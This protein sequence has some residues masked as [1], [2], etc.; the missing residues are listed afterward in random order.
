MTHDY[1]TMYQGLY[2]SSEP[3]TFAEM[4][5]QNC[6]YDDA[7]QCPQDKFWTMANDLV[8]EFVSSHVDAYDLAADSKTRY[9]YLVNYKGEGEGWFNYEDVKDSI[10]GRYVS[11]YN[12]VKN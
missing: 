10:E 11:K 5:V 6:G 2:A 7:K 12:Y 4:V 8:R 1:D 9:V 3:C